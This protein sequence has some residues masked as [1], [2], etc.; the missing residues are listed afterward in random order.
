LPLLVPAEREVPSPLVERL[1]ARE[2]DVVQLVVLGASNQEI[3]SQLVIQYSTAKKHVANLLSKLGAQSRTQ[4][5]AL[6]RELSLL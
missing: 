6:A 4:A 3:A 5:I 2:R 1:S